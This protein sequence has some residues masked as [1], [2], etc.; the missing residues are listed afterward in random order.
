MSE[1]SFLNHPD[2]SY[3]HLSGKIPLSTQLQSFNASSFAGNPALCGLPLSQKCWLGEQ[4]PNQSEAIEEYGDE[5]WKWF[6]GTTGFGFV[7]GFLG[8]CGSL[9]LKDSWRHAYFLLFEKM[10]DWLCV[11]MAVN[12]ARLRRKFQRPR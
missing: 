7:V 3:N 12:M 8:V 2:L 9:L 5:F 11:R 4:T 10:K 6:Y 1:I